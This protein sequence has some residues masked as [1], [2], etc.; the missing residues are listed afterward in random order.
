MQQA[1]MKAKV[2]LAWRRRISVK[3]MAVMPSEYVI[4]GIYMDV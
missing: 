4:L 1:D 2:A 3:V